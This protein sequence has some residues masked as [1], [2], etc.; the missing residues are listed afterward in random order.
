MVGGGQGPS[1]FMFR[2]CTFISAHEVIVDWSATIRPRVTVTT[3]C[4]GIRGHRRPDTGCTTE[5]GIHV[6]V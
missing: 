3:R 4:R 2:G 1:P 6:T 5:M